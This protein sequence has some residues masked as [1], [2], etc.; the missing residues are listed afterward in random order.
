APVVAL[1]L[2]GGA[3]AG[4]AGPRRL[5]F[6]ALIG[7]ACLLVGSRGLSDKME[8]MIHGYPVDRYVVWEEGLK[9]VPH[10]PLFGY[11]PASYPLVLPP[12]AW[13]KF[14]NRAP[15][16]WHNDLLET[17]LD[18]GPLAAC[19]LG[20]L[21]LLGA[22][23]ALKGALGRGRGPLAQPGREPGLL[24]LCLASCGLVGSVVTTSVLGLSFWVL[25]GLTLKGPGGDP[26]P[27][28]A[29]PQSS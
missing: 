11:G 22:L 27:G 12:A 10:V 7:G 6:Y 25:L 3:R 23:R 28:A 24:F 20:G 13:G 19:A 4:A 16:S 18:S 15:S 2:A 14:I 21:L 5:A 9:L 8:W 1:A 26:L 29:A 17:W